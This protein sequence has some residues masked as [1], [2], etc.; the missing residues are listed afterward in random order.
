MSSSTE[1]FLV[2]SQSRFK[3]KRQKKLLADRRQEVSAQKKRNRIYHKL[4]EIACKS[5]PQLLDMDSTA[6]DHFLKELDSSS[7]FHHI[8]SSVAKRLSES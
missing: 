8:V 2:E 7:E 1:D 6:L 4:G 5:V 3:Q